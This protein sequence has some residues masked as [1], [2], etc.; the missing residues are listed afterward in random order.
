MLCYYVLFGVVGLTYFG[1]S[2]WEQDKF[3]SAT[4]EYFGCNLLGD[5][6]KCTPCFQKYSHPWIEGLCYVSLSFIPVANFIFVVNWKEVGIV[7]DRLKA[8]AFPSEPRHVLDIDHSALSP[9]P[10]SRV[11]NNID[12]ESDYD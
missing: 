11:V 12:L 1:I 4:L 5:H 7:F 6:N 10:E 2:T 9:Y 3:I 8:K